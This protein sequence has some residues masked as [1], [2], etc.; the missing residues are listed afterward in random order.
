VIGRDYARSGEPGQGYGNGYRTGRLK[1]A[2]GL[3]D[4]RK[5]PANSAYELDEL[6]TLFEHLVRTGKMRRRWPAG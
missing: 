5:M 1:T 2:E 4:C 6:V 3:M